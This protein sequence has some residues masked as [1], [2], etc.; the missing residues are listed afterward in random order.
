MKQWKEVV[1]ELTN[2][3]NTSVSDSQILR[4][5]YVRYLLP[6]DDKSK[7]SEGFPP[8]VTTPVTSIVVNSS[9]S[10][11]NSS[12][13]PPA[14]PQPGSID[15]S[16]MSY[17][18]LRMFQPPTRGATPPFNQLP[19][20]FPSTTSTPQPQSYPG[21][22]PIPR[23]RY[24][25][26]DP[27]VPGYLGGPPSSPWVPGY[28]GSPSPNLSYPNRGPP[29]YGGMS[30]TSGY[31]GPSVPG[32]V[33]GQVPGYPGMR[34]AVPQEGVYLR[35]QLADFSRGP[36]QGMNRHFQHMPNAQQERSSM[37][38]NFQQQ[39]QH[40]PGMMYTQQSSNL[41]GHP[42]DR[43]GP[44]P[45]G[46]MAS[47][48]QRMQ[49]MRNQWGHNYL[50][51]T[52]LS[53]SGLGMGPGGHSP[54]HPSQSPGHKP[55]GFRPPP[56]YPHPKGEKPSPTAHSS[57][58]SSSHHQAMKQGALGSPGRKCE[59]LF[60]PGCVEATKPAYSKKRRL[61]ARDLGKH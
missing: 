58:A 45:T 59:G 19:S 36:S 4:E 55:P 24:R 1:Q 12:G 43:L 27:S 5:Q 20:S 41:A 47:P 25:N 56:P 31:H 3:T 42:L 2:S 8:T 7:S 14:N 18:N 17:K 38:P 32:Q 29:V 9:A 34:N 57:S 16:T 49:P 21:T 46:G 15:L 30:S 35:D 53:D 23:Q 54:F 52:A 51:G 10:Y 60:P 48:K 11:L 61:T 39:P 37:F 40:S 44:R 22:P 6:F 26:V 28:S 33:P 50:Q 13:T